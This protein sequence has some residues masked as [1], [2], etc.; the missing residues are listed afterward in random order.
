MC[1]TIYY[2]CIHKG[3]LRGTHSKYTSP[4]FKICQ[5]ILSATWII[6]MRECIIAMRS[7]CTGYSQNKRVQVDPIALKT[8]N[9]I[10]KYSFH[11]FKTFYSAI[12]Q[13]HLSL[14]IGRE[15]FQTFKQSIT[16]CSA[17]SLN[18]PFSLTDRL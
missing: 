4:R 17:S 10:T 5:N 16:S 12:M 8:S 18:K 1:V 11:R 13:S 9:P 3:G 2:W 7:E 15:P 14:K 6:E